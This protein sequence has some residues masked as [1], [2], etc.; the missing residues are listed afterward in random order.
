MEQ[1]ISFFPFTMVVSQLVRV[2]RGR[3]SC[4]CDS[5]HCDQRE[6]NSVVAGDD[7]NIAAPSSSISSAQE[8]T[9][10]FLATVKI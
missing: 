1:V 8:P 6:K 3:W 2:I 10:P 7:N 4:K 5:G 9:I